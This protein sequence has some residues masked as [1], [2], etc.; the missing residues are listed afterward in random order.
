MP[1][2]AALKRRTPKKTARFSVN[3]MRSQVLY[4]AAQEQLLHACVMRS[5]EHSDLVAYQVS[6]TT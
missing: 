1:A 4:W 2:A 3:F 5:K 6:D